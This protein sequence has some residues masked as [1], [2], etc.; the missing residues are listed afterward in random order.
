MVLSVGQIT[1]LIKEDLESNFSDL[2]IEGEISNL[3]KHVSGHW[4]FNLKD[5]D[6]LICCTMWK[7]YNNYVFFTPEDGM[8]IIAS[9]RITVYP[10]R[11]NYQLD[12]RHMKPSGVGD[13][14]AAFERLKQRLSSEGLFDP[15]FKKP[16]PSF[17]KRIGIVTAL[18][19]AAFRDMI[20]IAKRRYPLV[21][22]VIA[23]SKVQGEGAAKSIAENIELLNQKDDIDVI[24]VGR[25]GGSL[26]DLWAFNE[27]IVARAIFSSRIPIISAVGHEIDFTISD[28][29]A[30]LRAPTPSAAMEVATPIKDDF[31]TYIEDFLSKS[32]ENI[33][34]ILDQ[35]KE[36]I[37]SAINSY[38]FRVPQDMIRIRMQQTDNILFR[39]EQKMDKKLS[40]FSNKLSVL[41]KSLEGND[42][43][44]IL[45]KGFVLVKQDSKFVKRADE[46]IKDKPASLRFFDNEISINNKKDE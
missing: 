26:E 3:K 38:G 23:P 9:G 20:S 10:P 22:L 33:S 44:R 46:F 5:S 40:A 32:T 43:Q 41:S 35:K 14:Q 8:K 13:L 12:V 39:I 30:D 25:G 21:E 42:I 24:I 27:E 17:P 16:I 7:G 6:A 18:D 19:G 28:F 15:E 29:V 34:Y 45:K 36:R 11:G 1:R 31:F 37:S 2:S 4:Y